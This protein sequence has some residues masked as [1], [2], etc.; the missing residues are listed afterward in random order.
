[1]GHAAEV[2]KLA[3]KPM[4]GVKH[5]LL[6]G[7]DGFGAYSWERANIPNIKTLAS[8]G[9]LSLRARSVSP[10]ISAP[11]WGSHLMGAGPETHGHLS[12]AKAPALPPF[13][14]SKYGRFPGIYGLVRD[15]YPQ[16]EVG[17]LY[18]W[19]RI[20]DLVENKAVSFEK[21][22]KRPPFGKNTTDCEKMEAYEKSTA[23]TVAAAAEYIV[24]KKPLFTFV[25]LGA[26]DEAGH[27][28]GHDTPGY[29]ATLQKADAHVGSLIGA[30]KKT[31]IEQETV[32]IIV[33]DHGGYKKGHS[34]ARLVVF[35]T[36]WIMA[37]PGVKRGHSIESNIVSFDTAATIACILGL[38]APQV[39]RGRPVMEAFVTCGK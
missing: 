3:V 12:N 26:V 6:V 14:L 35:Q 17:L 28:W 32:V 36:P 34:E 4:P 29:H 19:E 21:E 8:C 25:Y 15:T 23:E 33:S 5:V 10:S 2:S 30:L 27:L 39:W 37:G 31:G 7:I 38:E 9:A 1:M 20:H 22:F 11:N 18:D 13:T 16:S 24:Q